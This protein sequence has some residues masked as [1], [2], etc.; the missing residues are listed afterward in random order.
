MKKSDKALIN[1]L[2]N[3]RHGEAQK[4]KES[5]K[6]IM[7]AKIDERR[8]KLLEAAGEATPPPPPPPPPPPADKPED[9]PADAGADAGAPPPPPPPPPAE[10]ADAGAGEPSPADATTTDIP[11]VDGEPSTD[12]TATP[13]ASKP[14]NPYK[15]YLGGVKKL[16]SSMED[17][18]GRDLEVSSPSI[19]MDNM[20][21][22]VRIAKNNLDALLTKVSLDIGS[23]AK[24]GTAGT[25]EIKK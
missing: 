13:D 17:V 3:V 25:E 9:K 10:G 8:K 1:F 18:I 5:L 19:V 2:G 7:D 22:F 15:E 21:N 12:A 14:A 23:K 6:A 11:S 4:A 24:G 16:V 20:S